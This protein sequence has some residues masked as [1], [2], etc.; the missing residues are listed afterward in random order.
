MPPP[1]STVVDLDVAPIHIAVDAH[2][3]AYVVVVRT[4]RNRDS[5]L[6]TFPLRLGFLQQFAP[7]GSL[8]SKWGSLGVDPGQF[9]EPHGI[10][11]D[12]DGAMY[13]ADALNG[14]VQ[15]LSSFGTPLAQLGIAG[16]GLVRLRS[17]WG[18][19]VDRGGKVYV[20]D[21]ATHGVAVFGPDG[22]PA[23]QWGGRG[24]KPGQ[25]HSPGGIAVDADGAVYVADTGNDRVQ[26]LSPDGAPLAHW[27]ERGSGPGRLNQP[28]SVAVDG[29]G[30]VFIADTGNYRV[31]K[32]SQ[33]GDV[34]ATWGNEPGATTGPPWIPS[35]LALDRQGNAYV[36]DVLGSRILKLTSPPQ[37]RRGDAG[38]GQQRPLPAVGGKPPHEVLG[39]AADASQE[40]IT[41]AYRK[42]ARQYHPDRVADLG[43]EFWEL[44]ERRMKEINAA[45]ETLR[46]RL[47]DT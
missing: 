27:G 44:A 41:A 33:S 13:V 34:L 10:A 39:V 31:Q 21:R 14:R 43:P 46:R 28:T 30:A 35:D 38:K 36:A 5:S 20:T 4:E 6:S 29:A 37:E 19:A 9:Q 40:E 8:L 15:K 32:L 26:K 17:P 23:T 24:T 11:V 25:F 22:L 12:A 16:S 18:V 3:N 1:I 47:R 45:H 7:S 42:L 2:G